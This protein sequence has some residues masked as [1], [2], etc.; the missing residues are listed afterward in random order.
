MKNYVKSTIAMVFVSSF[1]FT[2]CLDLTASDADASL[3]QT[4][5]QSATMD[6]S[7]IPCDFD[8]RKSVNTLVEQ[9]GIV[10][11]LQDPSRTDASLFVIQ[12]PGEAIRYIAC[13]MP[14][15]AKVDGMKI[16][17]DAEVKEIYPEEKWMASP[18]KLLKIHNM[19]GSGEGVIVTTS[20]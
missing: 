14:E 3:R 1:A 19:E 4:V 18:L 17:F 15:S 5:A 20:L 6:L 9:T 10:T 12:M 2:S 7:S 11:K 8:S 13:N 16:T